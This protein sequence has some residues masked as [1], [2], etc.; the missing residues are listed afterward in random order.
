[1]ALYHKLDKEEVE[2]VNYFYKNTNKKNVVVFD[3]G[4]NRGLYVDLFLGKGINSS[5]HCF[6]PIESLY[7]NLEVKYNGIDNIKLNKLCVSNTNNK[8]TFC[9]LN[10]PVTDGCSSIIERS[11]FKEKGWGYKKYEIESTT[12]DDYCLNYNIPFIDFLKVDVEGAEFLVLS[13][14]K[15]M[16]S[17]KSIGMIQFEYGNTFDDANVKLIDVYNLV[18]KYGYGIFFYKGNV[19]NKVTLENIEEYSKITICNFV[20]K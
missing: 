15:K 13:G 6:E 11:V 9:E 10:D 4:C 1:M 20:I 12:I 16:I 3:V 2:I 7:N 19:F 5:I 17:N 14:A 8:V 18:Y